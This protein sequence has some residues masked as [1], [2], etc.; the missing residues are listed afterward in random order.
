MW[1]DVGVGDRNQHKHSFLG[2]H[3]IERT[4]VCLLSRPDRDS[5]SLVVSADRVLIF[6]LLVFL[7]DLLSAA[8]DEREC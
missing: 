8:A 6:L 2:R 7:S 1:L 4:R 5:L 3:V